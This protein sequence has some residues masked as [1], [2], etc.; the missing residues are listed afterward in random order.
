MER[1]VDS[2]EK[3]ERE[4]SELVAGEIGWHCMRPT[5]GGNGLGDGMAGEMMVTSKMVKNLT[6]RRWL[7]LY[8]REAS[9]GASFLAWAD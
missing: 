5:D 2:T 4:N 6:G 1:G 9:A 8:S 3:L 7:L